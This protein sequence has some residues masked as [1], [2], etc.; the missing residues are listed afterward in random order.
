[1]NQKSIFDIFQN[2]TLLSL[3]LITLLTAC[4]GSGG[5]GASNSPN[6]APVARDDG[7]GIPR[8]DPVSGK[9][10]GSDPEGDALGFSIV[11]IPGN[12]DVTIDD[13]T[14]GAYT[15]KPWSLADDSFTFVVNDGNLDSNVATIHITASAPDAPDN[16]SVK[17]GD[18]RVT[19]EGD[20]TNIADS[21][22]LYWSH[23]PGTG[24]AGNKISD[25]ELPYY[26]DGLTNGLN[27]YYVLTAVNAVGESTASQEIS[28]TPIDITIANL[29]FADA[30]L[31]ACVQAA[32]IAQGAIHVHELN[33]SLDCTNLAI[34]D[35]AGID[36][37]SALTN[38]VLTSNNID[39]LAPLSA[40][41][42]LFNLRLGS[43]FINDLAPLSGLNNLSYL[44]LG[45]NN[46]SDVNPLSALTNL[47]TLH[48]HYNNISD[49]ASLSGLTMLSTLY[50]HVNNIS[51]VSPLSGMT[52]LTNL[53][54]SGNNISDTSVFSTM[55]GLNALTL[56]ANNIDDASPL[57]GLSG[58]SSLDLSGN[59]LVDVSYLA[60]L[61]NLDYLNLLNNNIGGQG[62]GNVD[63]L[64]T[65]TSASTL[66][67][68]LNIAQSCSELQ[69]LITALGAVVTPN[70]ATDG[71]T[72][73]NP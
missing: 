35:I 31:A 28:A 47:T 37:L 41:T 7:F 12:G 17:N 33:G 46:I 11:T 21:Y 10:P 64:V 26:H 3:S 65:L 40:L 69:T 70:N 2:K 73:T 60:A 9:L 72:C 48:L 22:N 58:L 54:L 56:G 1:M 45:Q 5:G 52:N 51:V 15:Y 62:V 29:V 57:A 24:V 4:G 68:S 32:A 67:I 71:V 16:I 66:N 14:T 6:S 19:L 25:I 38:L 42:E 18:Q 30:G 13:A 59:N 8:L 61:T 53:V 23:T 27:Y 20:S 34:N 39:D 43:N 63:Q 36:E 50:L 49:I 44:L 55:T